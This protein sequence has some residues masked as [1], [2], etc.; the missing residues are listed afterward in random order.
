MPRLYGS[1]FEDEH[2]GTLTLRHGSS[3]RVDVFYTPSQER[4]Q[5]SGLGEN[6][7]E[8]YRARLLRIDGQRKS[9][10]VFPIRTTGRQD[11][12]M[13]PKYPQVERITIQDQRHLEIDFEDNPLR[14]QE[15]VEM[16]LGQLPS[17]F[18]KNFDWGLGLRQPYRFIVNAVEDLSD[19]TEIL[20]TD[21]AETRIDDDKGIFLISLSDFTKIRKAIDGITRDGQLDTSSANSENTLEFFAAKLGQARALEANKQLKGKRERSIPRSRRSMSREAQDAA[22][23]IVTESTET[24]AKDQ[25]DRLAT[26]RESIELVTLKALV[27]RFEQM[28]KS[29][30]LEN[31]WQKFL[32][33]NPFLLSLAFGYPVIKVHGQASVGGR[34]LS[35]RGDKVTDFLVKNSMTSNCAIVEI[36][37]PNTKL[38]NDRAAH[39]GVYTPSSELVGAINQALDQ[40]YQFDRQIAQIKENS[41]IY[42]IKSYAV[43]CCLLIGSMPKDEDRQKSFE[44]FRGNSKDVDIVTF[45]ELLQKLMQIRDFLMSSEVEPNPPIQNH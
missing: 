23:T 34:K 35:G 3:D 1:A 19:C 20:I 32:D 5:L 12:F 43:H 21:R 39:N 2:P 4:V 44:L 7:T 40:K 11:V 36:K 22:L 30:F 24:I 27:D 9:L 26:L 8:T 15:D 29:R 38:L 37:R 17:C 41:S 16:L 6:D 28:T 33:D 45:D 18:V 13:K 10:I 42:D 31:D 14:T 25:P